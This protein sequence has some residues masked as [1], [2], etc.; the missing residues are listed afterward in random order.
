MRRN[1]D[2]PQVGGLS[3]GEQREARKNPCGLESC[4]LGT[5]HLPEMWTRGTHRK[6]A[7]FPWQTTRKLLTPGAES[8]ASEGEPNKAQHPTN[9]PTLSVSSV[10][11][12]VDWFC[13]WYQG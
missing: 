13:Q 9:I 3:D 8:R 12:P 6:R 10:S 7:C 2:H 4:G 1:Y 5:H 11:I